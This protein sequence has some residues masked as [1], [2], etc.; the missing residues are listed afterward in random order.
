MET[1]SLN[2]S[3]L[4]GKH[5]ARLFRSILGVTI[6]NK[7]ILAIAL[8]DIAVTG[9]AELTGNSQYGAH[10][11]IDFPLTTSIGTSMICSTWIVR[12]EEKFPNLVSVYPIKSK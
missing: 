11:R 7:E 6:E 3:H 10:Y 1:Y 2:F 4:R 8:T 12:T 9:N 5:K